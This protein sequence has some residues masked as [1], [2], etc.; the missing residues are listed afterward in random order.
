MPLHP[1]QRTDVELLLQQEWPGLERYLRLMVP[2]ADVG[3]IVHDALED[4]MRS[5]QEEIRH[6][7]GYLWTIVHSRLRDHWRRYRT[8]SAGELD[9][10][11]LSVL[12]IGPTLSS[13]IGRKNA[14]M[15]ALQALT[16]DEMQAV[17]LV[18]CVGETIEDAARIMNMSVSTFN[19]RLASGRA[20]LRSK[21]GPEYGHLR[22]HYDQH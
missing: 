22:T 4:Y 12:E 6:P 13:I 17:V 5:P 7:R 8:R 14:V 11:K 21:L 16:A 9:T 1:S 19:R 15:L 3:D 20:K 18:D 2:E 10:S